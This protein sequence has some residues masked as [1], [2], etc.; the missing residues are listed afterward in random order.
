MS[1]DLFFF[2]APNMCHLDAGSGDPYI[3]VKNQRV[4]RC[5]WYDKAIMQVE[6]MD[7]PGRKFA[8]RA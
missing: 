7:Y 4:I 3:A 2:K 6:P 8:L 5:W 1:G